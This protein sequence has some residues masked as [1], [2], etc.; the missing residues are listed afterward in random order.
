MHGYTAGQRL[1]GIEFSAGHWVAAVDGDSR[2]VDRRFKSLLYHM[3]TTAACC[4][5]A[6]V[7]ACSLPPLLLP[8]RT[9]SAVQRGYLRVLRRLPPPRQYQT[10]ARSLAAFA[11]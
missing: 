1:T 11:G 7:L 10:A 6:V 3:A 9:A 4:S 8:R 5:I 2:F